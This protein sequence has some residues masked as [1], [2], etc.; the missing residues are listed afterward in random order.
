MNRP[1]TMRP[2]NAVAESM[3]PKRARAASTRRWAQARAWCSS[4][5]ST[6]TQEE[7]VQQIRAAEDQLRRNA[8]SLPRGWP[9]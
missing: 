6:I 5:A 3:R 7:A 2:V 1:V 8:A 4:R 9:E